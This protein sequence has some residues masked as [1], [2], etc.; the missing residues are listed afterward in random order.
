MW[1][2]PSHHYPA[3]TAT[4]KP[5]IPSKLVTRIRLS[6]QVQALRFDGC[7]SWSLATV[8]SSQ[9]APLAVM[10]QCWVG[11][12]SHTSPYHRP[13]QYPLVFIAGASLIPSPT[14]ATWLLRYLQHKTPCHLGSRLALYCI[15]I[16]AAPIAAAQVILISMIDWIPSS[17]SRSNRDLPHH[18]AGI[19]PSNQTNPLVACSWSSSWYLTSR[20][21]TT[22]L[23]SPSRASTL[24]PLQ[25]GQ[26]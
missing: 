13:S 10:G 16:F 1:P 8:Q 24:P 17:F 5:V 9:G 7:Y 22:V 3:N 20:A 14:I 11:Y 6:N 25:T 2:M 21:R 18:Y 19:L 12:V 26:T 4:L 23:P 15:P